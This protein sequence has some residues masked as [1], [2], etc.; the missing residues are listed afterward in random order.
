MQSLKDVAQQARFAAMQP[1]Q[2]SSAHWH[3]QHQDIDAFERA[4]AFAAES[5]RWRANPSRGG[6]ALS[7]GRAEAIARDYERKVR[8]IALQCEIELQRRADRSMLG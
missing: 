6:R 5:L 3:Q 2:I 7:P 8:E 1:G 4:A